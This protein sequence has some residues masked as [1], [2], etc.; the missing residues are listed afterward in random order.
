MKKYLPSYFFL[1]I[2]LL[3]ACSSPVKN[4][5][6]QAD[7]DLQI[8][9]SH[10]D[11]IETFDWAKEKARF[12]VQTGKEGPVDVWEKGDGT[13]KVTYIPS[14]WAG[15]PGRSAFY[16]RDFCHQGIGAHLLGLAEENFVMMKAFAAS[17][18]QGKKWFPLWAINFDGSPF[19][20]DYRGDD[21]FVREVPA[22]FELVE[23]AYELYLWT[24]DERYI[25]DEVLWNYYTQAVTN[26]ISFHDTQLPNGIAEGTGKGIFEGAAS[27]NEQRDHP[28]IESGD[29]IATQYRA[30][31]AYAKMA[32]LRGEQELSET[33]AQKASDLYTY[34]NQEW[35]IKGTQSYNRGYLANGEAVEGW[36][37][38]NSW[39]MAMKGITEGG[40]ERTKAYLD[41]IHERLESKDDIPDNI[42]AISYLPETFFLHHQNERGWRWMEHIMNGLTLEH[43]HA[44][45]T[46]RNGDY[47]EVSY[48]LIQNI[49][50]DL[51]GLSPHAHKNSLT[52][53]SHLPSDIETLGIQHVPI[54]KSVISVK[55]E[56]RDKTSLSYQK[57]EG[58]FTWKA[59]F[60]GLH[61]YLLV[62]GTKKPCE[63]AE[64][65]GQP[66]SY[67]T[68]TLNRGEKAVVSKK[69]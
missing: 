37:K 19:L 55:H 35:G 47:P 21:D 61:E 32:A 51:M 66:Y 40:S 27:Y 42:E 63:Q 59:G 4:E 24:G 3:A 2:Y 53:I 7:T 65:Y 5:L 11:L 10:P 28:L 36:G 8:E 16:S 45:A 60:S 57:G 17:A 33:F 52:S 46:G 64:N 9:S 12:Y 62:N 54:G 44:I 20:L 29:G 50:R 68:L 69:L 22:T 56:K 49:V 41:F 30:F 23:K 34:F 31:E 38:E 14:Y 1:A 48:V 15:Y 26:F 25:E 6:P 13:G 67:V 18:D 39:F 58:P 43:T